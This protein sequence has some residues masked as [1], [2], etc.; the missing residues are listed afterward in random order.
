[1]RGAIY[2]HFPETPSWRGARLKHGDNFTFLSLGS[3]RLYLSIMQRYHYIDKEIL[4]LR[5]QEFYFS[6]AG[7]AISKG[8]RAK[9][10][11]EEI[12]PC[13]VEMYC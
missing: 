9:G 7:W 3:I 6:V 8:P 10:P 4:Q 11:H 13:T 2:P 5:D 1:M 12:N